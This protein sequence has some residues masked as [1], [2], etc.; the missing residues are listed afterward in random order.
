MLSAL[1]TDHG[2]EVPEVGGADLAHVKEGINAQGGEPLEEHGLGHFFANQRSHFAQE[3]KA[4]REGREK[5]QKIKTMSYCVRDMSVFTFSRKM[6][7]GAIIGK[8]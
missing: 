4:S 5:K 1:Q 2:A 7:R 8:W 3:L 6:P